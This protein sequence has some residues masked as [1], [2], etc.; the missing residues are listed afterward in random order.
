MG[1]PARPIYTRF[2]EKVDKSAGPDQC[3]PW[4][5]TINKRG[6]GQLQV[7]ST[8]YV[9]AHRLAAVYA[10]GTV[11]AGMCVC[12]HCD[13]RRCC[14]PAHL[15]IGTA[16][17][18]NRDCFRKGRNPKGGRKL[19]AEQVLAIRRRYATSRMT[20]RQLARE[21]N[22]TQPQIG[23]IVRGEHWRHLIQ[24]TD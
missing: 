14:N 4:I 11:P 20:Q 23:H 1:Y 19:T 13:N 15:F 10:F 2:C 21:Y 8:T 12:H 6:Y 17:D 16:G 5:G 24:S 22:V 7:T 3:W 9:S 18:N